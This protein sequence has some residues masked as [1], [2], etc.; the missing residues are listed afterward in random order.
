MN[1]KFLCF[2]IAAMLTG[3]LLFGCSAKKEPVNN[4]SD[5]NNKPE[6]ITLKIA[7]WGNQTR[8]DKTL[9][10]IALF[11]SQNPGVKLEPEYYS[12][13]DYWTKIAAAT[14]GGNM[15]DIMQQDYSYIKQYDSRG[16]LVDLSPYRAN[17]KLNLSDAEESAI[18]GGL[19]G[20]KLVGVNLGSNCMATAYDPEMFKKAGLDEPSPDWTWDEY[21]KT[22]LTLHEKLDVFGSGNI[23]FIAVGG[24]T[25]YLRQHG[26]T[27]YSADGKSLGYTDDKY[28]IDFFN[29]ELEL[30]K[31][32]ALPGPAQRLEIKTPEQE[33]IVTEKAVMSET[34]SNQLIALQ[35]AANRPLKLI[36]FPNDPNQVQNGQFI[37]PSMFFSVTKDCKNV[38]MAVKFIDFITNDVEANKI[39]A[40]ERG[41]PISSKIRDAIKPTLSDTAKIVFDYVEAV[42]KVA[43]PIDPPDPEASGQIRAELEDLQ[44]Q[45]LF[46]RISV[47]DAAATFRKKATDLLKQ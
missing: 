38:D 17:G 36:S 34:N 23:S 40:A 41:V 47:E 20:N 25:A 11:E 8:T 1:K 15:P 39:L 31:A 9:E 29:M 13:G 43:S 14:A 6:E 5:G 4:G 16:L 21:K 42:S 30:F 2:T 26:Q 18:S 12:W 27:L 32:G 46:G 19:V 44:Q 28:F 37:K 22:V 45:I 24:L 3:T 33:L 10:V 35:A 7:W